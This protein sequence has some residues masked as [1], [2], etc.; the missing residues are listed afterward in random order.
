MD[1]WH[2]VEQDKMQQNMASDQGLHCLQIVQQFFLRNIY[3]VQP[4]T[5]KIENGLFQ[6]IEW[7]GL[8]SL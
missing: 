6:Y 2:S 1:N 3:I 4:D 8:F 7:E 5:P